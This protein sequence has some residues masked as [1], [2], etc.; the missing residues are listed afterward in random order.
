ML[1]FPLPAP[2]VERLVES[3]GG[4]VELVDVRDSDGSAQLVIAP[5]VSR[6]LIG[7][8]ARA[9]PNA[10]VLLVELE[11]SD[12][13]VDFGGPVRRALDA[14]ADGYVVARSIG[15]L[16]HALEHGLAAGRSPARPE[17]LAL[18]MPDIDELSEV[19]DVIIRE[20]DSAR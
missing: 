5:S 20:R 12:L 16:A 15:E 1:T 2:A 14:G 19:L 3:V 11:D 10:T 9:F 6:Q 4:S 18:G 7:K 17:P 13:G 8:L